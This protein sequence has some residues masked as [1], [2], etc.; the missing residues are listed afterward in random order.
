MKITVSCIHS[1]FILLKREAEK[2]G[3]KIKEDLIKRNPKF[4]HVIVKLLL[5]DWRLPED[6]P[7]E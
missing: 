4:S 6:A 3:E 2:V 5:T 7:E 1:Y